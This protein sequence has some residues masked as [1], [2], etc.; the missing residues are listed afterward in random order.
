MNGNLEPQPYFGDLRSQWLLTIYHKYTKWDYSP[1]TMLTRWGDPPSFFSSYPGW[2]DI[3][4]GRWADLLDSDDEDEE[5]PVLV[6]FW[7][8]G[9]NTP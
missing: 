7:P 5:C 9:F 1:F 2:A 3:G 8:N 6:A 4:G